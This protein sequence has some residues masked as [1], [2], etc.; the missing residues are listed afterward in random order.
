[1]KE[2]DALFKNLDQEEFMSIDELKANF[3]AQ[4]QEAS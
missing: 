4:H 1:M 3:V 2:D